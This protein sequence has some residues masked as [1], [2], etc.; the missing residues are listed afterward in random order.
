MRRVTFF[1]QQRSTFLHFAYFHRQP[2]ASHVRL[3]NY[4]H[5]P[6]SSRRFG[7]REKDKEFVERILAKDPKV[8]D[9]I[10]RAYLKPLYT[11]AKSFTQDHEEAQDLAQDVLIRLY[12]SLDSFRGDSM[13]STWLH[14]VTINTH[15]NNTRTRAY[16]ASKTRSEFDEEVQQVED[17]AYDVAD[18]ERVLS[19]KV[20][21]EHI[22]D[23]LKSLSPAQRMVFVLRHYHDLPLKEIAEHMGNSEGTV[24]V[25]LFRAIQNLQKKLQFYTEDR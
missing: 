20:I 23:A 10:F 19:Q 15:I 25:L 14:R 5:S 18:P 11:L 8:F 24:K 13:L 12:N 17:M 4:D 21:D 7:T 1:T 9:D 3:S 6:M 16:E 2:L 22:H